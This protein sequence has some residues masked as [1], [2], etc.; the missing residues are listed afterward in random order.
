MVTYSSAMTNWTT[1]GR[2]KVERAKQHI[3]SLQAEI[4]TLEEGA[5]L[6]AL[7]IEKHAEY[8]RAIRAALRQQEAPNSIC[9][10]TFHAVVIAGYCS[11]G[12][13]PTV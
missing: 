3:R 4:A 1:G 2:V 5:R 8:L 12:M 9:R 10:E 11:P 13:R 6:G 7:L